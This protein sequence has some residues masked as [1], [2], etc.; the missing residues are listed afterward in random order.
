MTS[1]G[2]WVWRRREKVRAAAFQSARPFASIG[3]ILYK[4]RSCPAMLRKRLVSPI[5]R[6]R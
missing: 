1:T 2:S 3:E 4:A 5:N 6:L